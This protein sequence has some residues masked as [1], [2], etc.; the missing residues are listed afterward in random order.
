MAQT[1][2]VARSHDPVAYPEGV[3]VSQLGRFGEITASLDPDHCN[4]RFWIPGHHLGIVFLPCLGLDLD[5]VGLF[6]HVIVGEDEPLAVDD[7][8]RAERVSLH[9]ALGSV[10]KKTPEKLV[11]KKVLE[12]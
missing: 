12:R 1:K 8:A 5:L 10:S 11:T 2:G 6:H 4:I 3:R 7:K 9:G